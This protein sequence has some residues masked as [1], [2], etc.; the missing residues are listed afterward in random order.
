MGNGGRGGTGNRTAELNIER[1]EGKN[2]TK[3]NSERPGARGPPN[4]AF[5]QR[6][7][8]ASPR[9]GAYARPRRR[10]PTASSAR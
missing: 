1:M 5:A 8:A 6:G 3:R 9:P 10:A 2:R 7:G 4:R